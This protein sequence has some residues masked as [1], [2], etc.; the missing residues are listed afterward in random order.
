MAEDSVAG[1]VPEEPPHHR[2]T[3]GGEHQPT[4]EPEHAGDPG[5]AG[6]PGHGEP[7]HG[8]G[9]GSGGESSDGD[10]VGKC[11]PGTS[12]SLG[13]AMAQLYGPLPGERSEEK[14]HL[15]T[16]AELAPQP[17]LDVAFAELE[18]LAHPFGDFSS[19]IEAAKAAWKPKERDNFE[20]ELREL[21]LALLEASKPDHLGAY[22]LGR[23]LSDTCWLPRK[24]GDATELLRQFNRY[25]L[26]NLREWLDEAAGVLPPFSASV[27]ARSLDNW[28]D[29][30][31]VNSRALTGN[32]DRNKLRVG[33]AL[34]GQSSAWHAVLSGAPGASTSP[35]V[36]AW[37]QAGESV[38]RTARVLGRRI[39]RRFFPLV[40]AIAAA[41]AALMWLAVKDASGTMRVWT[42]LVA[43]A[44]SVGVS[45]ASFKSASQKVSSG[46]EQ[47]VWNA[48]SLD[49]RA[50]E[51]TWLPA[52]FQGPVRR[53]RL[54]RRGVGVPS[55]QTG[56]EKRSARKA[57]TTPAADPA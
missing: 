28:Q 29:W 47:A 31:E 40:V 41:T 1:A 16:V 34:I 3:G 22:Q 43:A 53:L 32:W 12:F 4:G 36:N 45:G 37:M 20:G 48:A 10:D 54:G 46:I 42:A 57:D 2:R 21:N 19:K 11:R 8:D 18:T 14:K 49:A 17:R 38:M 35:G 23:A 5:H 15:A 27:V 25:R 6:E 33:H 26:S 39:L 9:H 50:W 55:G 56:L 52:I 7:G 30:C 44:G 13:W 51:V 24:A